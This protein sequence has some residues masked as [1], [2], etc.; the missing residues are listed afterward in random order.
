MEMDIP[1]STVV[2]YKD[3]FGDFLSTHGDGK[4]KKYDDSAIEVLNEVRKLREDDKLDWLEIKDILAEKYGVAEKEEEPQQALVPAASTHT[5]VH[6]VQTADTR[7]LEHMVNVLAGEVI[8]LAGGVSDVKQAVSRQS[9]AIQN[10]ENRVERTGRNLE[11]V[12]AEMLRRGNGVDKQELKKLASSINGEFSSLR[13]SV[14]KL[15]AESTAPSP[16]AGENKELVAVVKKVEALMTKSGD[17]A[18]QQLILKENEVLKKK[19]KEMIL[20]QRAK[21]QQKAAAPAP[22]P[23]PA[24][25]VRHALVERERDQ[26]SHHSTERSS[27]EDHGDEYDSHRKS[28]GGLFS[29]LKKR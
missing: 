25:V 8:K 11:A 26:H 4:R 23:A 12:A 5:T 6:T 19:L 18:K 9:A 29:F 14:K 28:K 10:I 27:H 13:E 17:T 16:A 21:Q 7:H 1:K 15:A 20:E 2:K 24:P 3:Y 22:V